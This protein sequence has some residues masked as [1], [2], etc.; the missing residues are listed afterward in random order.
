MRIATGNAFYCPDFAVMLAD[1]T[2]QMHEIKAGVVDKK[3][4][5]LKMLAEEAARVRIKVAADLFPFQFFVAINRPKK[6]GGGFEVR[7][8]V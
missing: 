8:M 6:I 5:E 3:T 4:G 1:G 7:E 2:L